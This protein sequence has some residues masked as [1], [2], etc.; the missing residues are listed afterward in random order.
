MLC[1]RR[2]GSPAAAGLLDAAVALAAEVE[3]G[4]SNA[5]VLDSRLRFAEEKLLAQVRASQCRG[6]PDEGQAGRTAS[7]PTGGTNIPCI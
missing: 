1:L 2:P 4:Q 6:R 7:L 5:A 3:S